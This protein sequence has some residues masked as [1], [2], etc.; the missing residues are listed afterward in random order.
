MPSWKRARSRA[1]V[2]IRW[3]Q[4]LNYCDATFC[5]MHMGASPREPVRLLL[6]GDEGLRL[7]KSPGRGA[8]LSK[9]TLS[10]PQHN[11]IHQE[12]E[13]I[14]QVVLHQG[15]DKLATAVD[16]QVLTGLLLQLGDLFCDVAFQRRGVPLE[17]VQ[18]PRRHELGQ[19]VHAVGKLP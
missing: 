13:L 16:Q 8:P 6:T 11:R 3:P 5:E 1:E 17:L 12:V 10:A 19:A 9:Q 15:A 18:C 2:A 7:Y 14:D 4:S